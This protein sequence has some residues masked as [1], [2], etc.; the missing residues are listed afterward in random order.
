[1]PLLDLHT[2]PEAKLDSSEEEEFPA[3]DR[4]RWCDDEPVFGRGVHCDDEDDEIAAFTERKCCEWEECPAGL[5]I[6]PEVL[7]PRD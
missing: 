3:I 2:L 7:T 6:G 1:M 4:R 5:G